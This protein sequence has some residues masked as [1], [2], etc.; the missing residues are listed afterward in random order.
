MPSRFVQNK[1]LVVGAS[2]LLLA[3]F[4]CTPAFAD[5]L[6]DPSAEAT[7]DAS[8]IQTPIDPSTQSFRDKLLSKQAQLQ[9][10]RGQLAVMDVQAQMAEQKWVQ[11]DDQLKALKSRVRTAQSDLATAQAAYEAQSK[12]L[13][14]RASA[15]YKEGNFNGLEVLLGS[16]SVGD[17]VS[18]VKFLN[19]LGLADADS[20]NSLEAQRDMMESQLVDLKNSEVQ[21]ASLEFE[22]KARK[23]EVDLGINDRQALMG[24]AQKDLL[25][26]LEKEAVNRSKAEQALFDEIINGANKAGIVALPGTPVETALAYHGI[27]Y[28]WAGADPSGFDCSGLMLY[29]FEQH[30][31]KLPHYSG[32]QFLMG[33]KIDRK[34]IL[35]NDVVFFGSPVH[36]VGLYC[37]G[38][39]FIE[40]PFTGSFCRVTK[41]SSRNDIAGFRRYPWKM[42]VGDPKG[43]VTSTSKALKSVR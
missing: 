32:S 26:M 27:P 16:K 34:D 38:G 39:Y 22:L 14:E 9:E 6:A 43:G 21:A 41:L 15:L 11:A 24:Q 12:I 35:P 8:A 36:H 13:A 2:A 31:V 5:P 1:V 28:V 40:E 20:A 29:V 23:R 19:T 10:L 25:A 4:W 37:G 17:F 33:E 18:R 7:T 30:G 42:R 3:A